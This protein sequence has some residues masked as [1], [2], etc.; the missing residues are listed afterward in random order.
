M[1]FFRIKT[2]KGKQ[3]AYEVENEW[4]AK[5]SRQKVKGYI[6]RT[7][8]AALKDD[9][10]F[11]EFINKENLEEYF[12]CSSRKEIIRNLIEWEIF[13]F[14]IG[15]EFQ[16]DL[17]MFTIQKKGK[18]IAFIINDG[19]MCGKTIRKLLEFEP[20]EDEHSDAY[21]LAR[22][23]VE[24]GIKVPHDVFIKLFEVHFMRQSETFKYNLPYKF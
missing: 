3:Y 18:N 22:A 21:S 17:D 15:E 10:G 13:K 5:S 20:Q 23:F 19:L 12:K 14:G 8:K 6:G 9:I 16:I 11:L 4:R 7:Y 1:V 24:A 2:I